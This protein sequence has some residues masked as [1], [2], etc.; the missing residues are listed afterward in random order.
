MDDLQALNKRLLSQM[1]VP[2]LNLQTT[3]NLVTICLAKLRPSGHELDNLLTHLSSLSHQNPLDVASINK[4]YLMYA[5]QTA[6]D[7]TMG[8]FDGLII[9]NIDLCQ[10]R[11]L[12]RLTNQQISE[13][14]YRWDGTIFEMTAAAQSQVGKLHPAAVPHYSTALLAATA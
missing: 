10:A 8:Y 1:E 3:I 6:R 7:I 5:R 9:L 14:S 2:N 11:V 4:E 12:A 13:L